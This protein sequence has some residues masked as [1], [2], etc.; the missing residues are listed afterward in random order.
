[1]D[2]DLDIGFFPEVKLLVT[3]EAQIAE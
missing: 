3:V 2:Y 1:M